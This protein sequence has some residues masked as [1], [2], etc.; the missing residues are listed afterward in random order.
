M[1]SK[2]TNKKQLQLNKSINMLCFLKSCLRNGVELI[3]Y[4]S[5]YICEVHTIFSKC[6]VM[7]CCMHFLIPNMNNHGRLK[8]LLK[9]RFVYNCEH[10]V[11]I[12]IA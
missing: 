6:L 4:V 1:Y 5:K 12:Y 2:S 11:E 7:V 10:M 8:H 3:R 9:N